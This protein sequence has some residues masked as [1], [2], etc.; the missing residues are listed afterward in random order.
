MRISWLAAA[1]NRLLRIEL[2]S[3][4]R[5]FSIDSR[6]LISNSA[7]CAFS[8]SFCAEISSLPNRSQPALE[9]EIHQHRRQ[10][11]VHQNRRSRPDVLGDPR[12]RYFVQLNPEFPN[13]QNRKRRDYAPK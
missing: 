4:A 9:K 2:S 13:R 11:Q 12:R 6:S 7:A 8:R 1:R 5:R 3:A 10:K